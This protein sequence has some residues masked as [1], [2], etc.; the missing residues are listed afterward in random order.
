MSGIRE[1]NKDEKRRRILD[2]TLSLLATKGF[3]ET[4]TREIAARAGVAV[5]TIFLYAHDKLDLFLMSIT[6]DLDKL[7]DAAFMEVAE[8]ADLV[9]QLATFFRPRFEFWA[10]WPELSRVATREM[11]AS[12]SPEAASPELARGL[13]RRAHTLLKIEEMLRRERER[14]R[15]QQKAD[16]GGIARIV[17][18]VYLGELRFWLGS[19]TPN[20]RVGV[21]NFKKLIAVALE[22]AINQP[23]PAHGPRA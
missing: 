11:A 2:S 9:D 19:E 21:A 1:R 15:L 14:G 22:G 12:H 17:L 10:R 13:R 5:G 20:A 23:S 4:T 3:Q 16:I 18:Y 7:T 8:N 6:E